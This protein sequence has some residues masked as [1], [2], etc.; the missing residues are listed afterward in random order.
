MVLILVMTV[1]SFA[2]RESQLPDQGDRVSRVWPV[3]K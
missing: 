1:E 2:T 3:V